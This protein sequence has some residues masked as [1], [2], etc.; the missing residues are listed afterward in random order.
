[1]VKVRALWVPGSVHFAV[2]ARNCDW[3]NFT[4][5]LQLFAWTESANK[6]YR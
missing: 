2:H 4:N 6:I 3:F 1:M 5:W